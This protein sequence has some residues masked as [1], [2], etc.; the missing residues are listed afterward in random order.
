[1]LNTK[2]FAPDKDYAE[3][4]VFVRA[5]GIHIEKLHGVTMHVFEII[6]LESQQKC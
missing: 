6:S 4:E 5:I 2:V 1:M 3:K